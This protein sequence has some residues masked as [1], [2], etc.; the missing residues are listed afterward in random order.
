M[1][2]THKKWARNM[3]PCRF[4]LDY[5]APAQAQGYPSMRRRGAPTDGS[6][7]LLGG[8]GLL[9]LRVAMRGARKELRKA[10]FDFVSRHAGA[11]PL[12]CP[13]GMCT[14]L[15]AINGTGSFE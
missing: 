15:L 3:P 4:M 10:S 6:V 13:A 12:S 11:V 5:G 2:P 7:S 14:G 1:K 8:G 9:W